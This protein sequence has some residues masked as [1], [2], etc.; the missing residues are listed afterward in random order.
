MTATRLA[1]FAVLLGTMLGCA[2]VKVIPADEPGLLDSFQASVA[3]DDLSPRTR[4]TLRRWDLEPLYR[5]NPSEAYAR[6]Q[7]AAV[8][9][10]DPEIVF[11]LAEVSYLFGKQIEQHSCLDACGYYYLCAGYSYHYLF[12]DRPQPPSPYDPR[13][14]LACDLYNTGLSKCI[15]AAQRAGRL[16]PR[17]VLHLPTTDSKGFTLSVQHHG[18]A[19]KPEEFGPLL[20]CSD[21]EVIGLAN[22]YRSYG[23]GVPLIGTRVAR[24]KTAGPAVYPREVSFPV[25]AFFRFEGSLADL[26]QRRAGRLELHNPLTVQSV[27]VH[28][29]PIPLET[30]LTTPLAYFLSR[31]DLE[32]IEYAGFLRPD[33]VEHRSGIYMFEPYQP[34]KIPV[35]MVHGLLASPLTWSVMFND[36]RADPVLRERYQFWFYLYPTGNPY[37]E[38]AAD[39][40][41]D[42]N[43]VR[44]TCDPAG[45]DPALDHMV[46]VS[47]SMGGLVSKLLTVNSG[48]AFWHL[49]SNEPLNDLKAKPAVRTDLQRLF[50]FDRQPG[51]ERVV[52]LGTP[53]RGSKLSPSVPGRLA[54]HLVELP[55]TLRNAAQDLMDENPQAAM[56]G[57]S[58]SVDLLA[59]A[60]PALEVLAARPRLPEVHYHSIIGQAPCD[61]T[62]REIGFLLGQDERYSDGVVP[63]ASAHLDG[64]DSEIVVDADHNQIHRHPLAVLE[65]RRILLE[66]L[67]QVQTTNPVALQE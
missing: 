52:F 13:F 17:Q 67:R 37:L 54:A 27:T 42:L 8:Q 33:K 39:L 60:S 63:Y 11:A 45:T 30:D 23:L 32:G 66:H 5:S 1:L 34:G 62:L 19:W 28:G 49:V 22:Q 7:A 15:H 58:N 20:L 9:S 18:F 53:H 61:S 3:H 41:E 10:A 25:T 46:F 64:V 55:K 48:D 35:V 31:T 2:T 44:A 36:L 38:A 40:R 43:Q 51:V 65:V 57:L 14:R 26:S 16:D 4:Q 47:H 50:F 21:Y 12:D 56:R 6:M 24:N 29:N 59:P